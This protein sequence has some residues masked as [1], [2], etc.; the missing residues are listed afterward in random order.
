ME[1]LIEKNSWRVLFFEDVDKLFEGYLFKTKDDALGA[2][3]EYCKQMSPSKRSN[4]NK[5][6]AK[7]LIMAAKNSKE[8]VIIMPPDIEKNKKKII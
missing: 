4:L 6:N 8:Y 1:T 7:R 3:L 2:A 5:V